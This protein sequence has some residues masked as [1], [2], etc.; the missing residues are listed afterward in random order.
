MMKRFKFHSSALRNQFY[1]N[2][3][4]VHNLI[5]SNAIKRGITKII[6]QMNMKTDSIQMQVYVGY[7]MTGYYLHYYSLCTQN[8]CNLIP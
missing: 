4:L 1:I 2:I 6:T 8:A 7:P 5:K 3:K